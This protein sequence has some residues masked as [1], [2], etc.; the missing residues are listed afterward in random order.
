MVLIDYELA[1]PDKSVGFVMGHNM[2]MHYWDNWEHLD[3]NPERF[4]GC[5]PWQDVSTK[6]IGPVLYDLNQNFVE[7]WDKPFT[8]KRDYDFIKDLETNLTGYR[9][10]IHPKN[11]LSQ[12]HK[13][14]AQI[15]RTQPQYS[16]T[17]IHDAYTIAFRNAHNYIY[18]ENQYFRH[19]KLTKYLLDVQTKNKKEGRTGNLYL[20]AVT[21]PPPTVGEAPTTYNVMKMLGKPEGMVAYNAKEKNMGMFEKGVNH[22]LGIKVK[23]D[24]SPQYKMDMDKVRSNLSAA[25]II[26]TIAN[27]KTAKGDPIYVHSKLLLVDDSFF[28][29]GS[30]NYN[31][32]SMRVDSEIAII[33]ADYDLASQS[34][35][36]LWTLHS[37]MDGGKCTQENM[38]AVYEKWGPQMRDNLATYKNIQKNKEKGITIADT[39]IHHLVNF[40]YDGKYTGYWGTTDA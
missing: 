36:A 30:A 26:V 9:S 21:N 28:L 33:T 16:K 13:L 20:F 24:D 32:R 31:D 37:G 15:L 35:Q 12:K 19:E 2:L 4:E 27:L 18:M 17:E 39:L 40:Y 25:G 29:L 34:R 10:S 7:A 38:S 14:H 3:N 23:G 6:V 8:T 11:F 22:V 1:N 5:G